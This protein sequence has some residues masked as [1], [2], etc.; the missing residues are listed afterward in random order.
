MQPVFRLLRILFHLLVVALLTLLTQV[1]GLIHL[2]CFPLYGRIQRRFSNKTTRFLLQTATFLAV[3]LCSALFIV[4]FVAAFF[5]RVAMPLNHSDIKPQHWMTVVMCR[6]YVRPKLRRT[7]I[8]V[9]VDM[10][11]YHQSTLLYLD[12]QHPFFDGWPLVPHLS[13][14]DGRKLDIALLW[15]DRE[16]D[17][18]IVGTPSAIGYGVFE[19]PI[20][21][22]YDR[23]AECEA[24]GYWQYGYME[25]IVSQGRKHLFKLDEER[26]AAMTRLFGKHPHVRRVL[27]EPYLKKRLQLDDLNKLRHHGCNAVRHDDHIHVELMD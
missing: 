1:G 24:K 7:A 18:P 20:P 25:K 11:R 9:A 19:D 10:K 5:G 17:K 3:Y 27:I 2:F 13:H 16:T 22:E 14:S 8:Q 26:T 4:P 6:H 15:K 21:T 23:T 12:A